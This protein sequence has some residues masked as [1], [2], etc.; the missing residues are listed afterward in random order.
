MRGDYTRFS[1]V[2]RKRYDALLQQQGRMQTDADWNEAA[3]IARR[4]TRLLGLD[5]FGPVWIG[6]DT[7]PDAFKIA[8]IVGPPVDLSIAPGRIYVDGVMAELF[9]DETASYLK[10]P[11]LPDPPALPAGDIAVY[12]DIWEREVTWVQDPT[13]LLDAALGGRDTTTRLQTVWQ[14]KTTAQPGATCGLAVGAPPSA[15]RL[16]SSAI[17]P[18]APD[19]PCLL[20]PVA[21]YRGLENRLYRVEIHNG[22]SMG[23]ARFKWS[24]DNGS[25][26]SAISAIVVAGGQT[27][28]TVSRLGRDAVL[29]FSIGDWVT[30]TDDNRE[31]AEEPGE[32]A[33]IADIQP[34]TTSITLDRALPSAG[35]RPF[36][37]N[38]TEI[39][40]RHTRVQRWDQTSTNTLDADGLIATGAALIPLEDGV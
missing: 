7:T 33:R 31:L 11:F 35:A 26:V 25:I 24:R 12:L 28:L 29:G 18:A 5:L 19:D 15:G 9:A 4:R 6:A 8:P 34:A 20:P 38:P 30:V 13:A 1:F 32:M 27:Q 17:A 22:G 14:V 10:Q 23:T 40:T 36:G 2:P 21:G 16:S 37:A 39:A 3:A